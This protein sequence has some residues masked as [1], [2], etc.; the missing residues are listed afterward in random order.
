MFII[1]LMF[2]LSFATI[3]LQFINNTYIC[4]TSAG[5]AFPFKRK[6]YSKSPNISKTKHN[7]N[8]IKNFYKH[9]LYDPRGMMR[10]LMGMLA[11]MRRIISLGIRL[12]SSCNA[13]PSCCEVLQVKGLLRT[14]SISHPMCVTCA[15]L[16]TYR[17]IWLATG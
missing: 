8:G 4:C 17:D 2:Y 6:L 14:D 3:T 1:S 5:Q 9:K 12:H 16:V 11:N 15:L 10:D 7:L 13:R